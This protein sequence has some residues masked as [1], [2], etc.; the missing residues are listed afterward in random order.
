MSFIPVS[1]QMSD[2]TVSE[3][4]EALNRAYTDGFRHAFE[5]RVTYMAS[6]P[7]RFRP[8]YADGYTDG[9]KKAAEL[10]RIQK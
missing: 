10:E 9:L 8:R 6:Y 5:G 4:L 7:P 3:A 1:T 2:L